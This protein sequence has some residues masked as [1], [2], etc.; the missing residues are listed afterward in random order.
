MTDYSKGMHLYNAAWEC[1]N[2][3]DTVVHRDDVNGVCDLLER[4]GWSTCTF[5]SPYGEEYAY[6]TVERKYGQ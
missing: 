1:V 4:S 2:N 3:G 5:K 6:I